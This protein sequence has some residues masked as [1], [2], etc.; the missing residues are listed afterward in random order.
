MKF[1]KEIHYA[2]VYINEL[3][4]ISKQCMN[5]RLNYMFNISM[6]TYMYMVF[7]S[8]K[9]VFLISFKAKTIFVFQNKFLLGLT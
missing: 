8:T 1:T 5:I 2:C 7:S 6:S 9:N 3:Y 4:S